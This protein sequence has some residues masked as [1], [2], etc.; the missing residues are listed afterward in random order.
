MTTDQRLIDAAPQML[1]A[2]KTCRSNV[3]SLGPAGAIEPYTPYLE[4]L[5]VLDDVIE[6]A[7]GERP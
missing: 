6:A 2:L 5:R 7:T 4:W 1:D 3:R